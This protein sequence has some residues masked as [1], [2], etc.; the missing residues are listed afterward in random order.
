[1]GVRAIAVLMEMNGLQ[2]IRVPHHVVVAVVMVVVSLLGI[3]AYGAA[4][5]KSARVDLSLYGL[6]SAQL[7]DVANN[8]HTRDTVE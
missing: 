2:S 5:A 1:M 7:R 3:A 4:H 6:G 8:E